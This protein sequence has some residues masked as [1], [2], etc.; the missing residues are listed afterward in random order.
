MPYYQFKKVWTPLS[1]LGIKLFKDDSNKLW[2][3][4]WN[5]PRRL[6]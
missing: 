6:L 2:V 5:K 4:L 1:L 3:K